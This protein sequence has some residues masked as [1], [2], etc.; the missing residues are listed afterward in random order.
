MILIYKDNEIKEMDD[1]HHKIIM[2][3]DYQLLILKYFDIKKQIIIR[4]Q[5]LMIHEDITYENIAEYITTKFSGT[6]PRQIKFIDP[7][8]YRQKNYS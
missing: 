4:M 5:F 3:D 2:K 8:Y 1:G 6:N 7:D